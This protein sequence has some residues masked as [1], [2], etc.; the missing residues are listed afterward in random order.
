MWLYVTDTR[1][2]AERT[3]EQVLAPM[4]NRPVEALRELALPIGSPEQCAERIAA[5]RDAGAERV[6]VW[7]LADELRQLERFRADVVPVVLA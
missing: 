6:F 7:P 2:E 3:L 4:V 5:Y 1:G